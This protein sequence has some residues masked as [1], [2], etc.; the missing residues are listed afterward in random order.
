MK[1]K[2]SK[3]KVN[4]WQVWA[5]LLRLPN[6]FTVPGDILVGW[7]LS[8]M[9]GCFPLFAIA[10][11]LSLYSAGLLLNDSCDAQIDAHERPNRPIPSGRIRLRTVLFVAI[12]LSALGLLLSG[13]GFP[14]AVCLLGLILFYNILAKHLPWIG[15][16][17]MGCCR[18]ANL[19]LGA[20]AT[21]PIG[22]MPL[23]PMLG[24]AVL[25]FIV[26]IVLV[27]VIAKN[28]A[29]PA[30][31]AGK[32]RLLAPGLTLLLVPLFLWC[33]RGFW[34]TPLLVALLMLPLVCVKRPVPALV[35][36]LIRFLIP[37]QLTW[38]LAAYQTQIVA[39]VLCFVI[40][41]GGALW[42]SR[43]ISGS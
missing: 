14:I 37:L 32:H 34:W 9:R 1:L 40:C 6:L 16:L 42:A 5:E 27:S 19:C 15:V 28:E 10:A 21:W 30:A 25:F 41:G 33:D 17:T 13:S 22:E 31:K 7:V 36:G 18:G 39:L 29:F 20:A 11:S 24:M 3:G 8:G 43:S 38:C 23:S 2:R 4:L 35:S 12:V 26:Y